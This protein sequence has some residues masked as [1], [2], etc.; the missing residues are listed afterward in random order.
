M[1]R[2]FSTFPDAS[3]SLGLLVLRLVVSTALIVRV[4]DLYNIALLKNA[5]PHVIAA[6]M[7]L[8]IL[9]GSWTRAAGTMVAVIELFVGFSYIDHPW[10]SLLLA[11]LGVTLAL[12]GPG[13]WSVDAQ[14]FGWKRIEI[15]RRDE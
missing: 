3:L 7:G 6:G 13:A 1:R 12:L 8:L 14:R 5:I 9:F 11:S 10:L 4:V 15:P 2:L